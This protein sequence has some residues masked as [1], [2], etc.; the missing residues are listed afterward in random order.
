YFKIIKNGMFDV[1]NS[2]GGTASIARLADIHVCGKTGTAQN[3]HGQDHSWFVAFAPKENPKIALCVFVENAG[4]GSQVAA[5]I[6]HKLMDVFF[7]PEKYDEYMGNTKPI[8]KSDSTVVIPP[9]SAMAASE[10]TR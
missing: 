4:F 1:V 10:I 9:D 6:A 2:T 3:P 7:H 8:R 5:P